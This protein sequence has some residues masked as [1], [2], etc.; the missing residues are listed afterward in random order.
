MNVNEIRRSRRCDWLAPHRYSG[1]SHKPLGEPLARSEDSHHRSSPGRPRE[2][3][4]PPFKNPPICASAPRL[5]GEGPQPGRE[6]PPVL[7]ELRKKYRASPCFPLALVRILFAFGLIVNRLQCS[8]A[9]RRTNRRSDESKRARPCVA[10]STLAEE[11]R[12]NGITATIDVS[13]RCWRCVLSQRR[14]PSSWPSDG[15][16]AS[17]RTG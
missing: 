10:L 5:R 13:M 8:L 4:A 7:L 3:T 12:A 9:T 1:Q 16:P 15:I 17:G 6:A 11:E 14:S 2:P